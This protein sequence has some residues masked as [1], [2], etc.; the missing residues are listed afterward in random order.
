MQIDRCGRIGDGQRGNSPDRLAADAKGLTAG[1]QYRDAGT[2][3]EDAVY[4]TGAVFDHVLAV[5]NDDEAA[6]PVQMLYQSLGH[7]LTCPLV[8]A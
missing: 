8:N 2:G 3:A 7:G 5:V 1:G 4:K 6:T